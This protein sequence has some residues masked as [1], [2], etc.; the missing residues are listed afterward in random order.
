MNTHKLIEDISN[1]REE[2]Q[3]RLLL[4]SWNLSLFVLR[5]QIKDEISF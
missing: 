3:V 4:T 5:I 2:I 1:K